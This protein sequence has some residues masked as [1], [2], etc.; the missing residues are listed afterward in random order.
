MET[1]MH[2]DQGHRGER[3]ALETP[4]ELRSGRG[5]RLAALLRHAFR[6]IASA[7]RRVTSWVSVEVIS[8]RHVQMLVTLDDRMLADIGVARH[9]IPDLVR[10]VERRRRIRNVP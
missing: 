4:I 3:S 9:Q 2:F 8:R 7:C 1:T 10:N 6:P 5:R